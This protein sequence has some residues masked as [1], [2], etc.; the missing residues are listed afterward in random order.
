MPDPF[1][2]AMMHGE[3]PMNK[4]TSSAKKKIEKDRFEVALDNNIESMLDLISF[5]DSPEQSL[6]L[7]PQMRRKK[8]EEELRQSIK[9]SEL[10]NHIDP[11]I[12]I[13]VNEGKQYLESEEYE[14][15]IV[16]FNKASELLSQLDL[17]EP[18]TEEF[19]TILS[20]S[21]ETINSIFKV[22]TAK[23]GEEQYSASLDLFVFLTVLH[24]DNFDYWYR[25]GISA[26][27]CENY[28]LALQAYGNAVSL[29]PEHIGARLFATEC[30]LKLDQHQEAESEYEVAEKISEAIPL[31]DQWREIFEYV[32][33]LIK[34]K[35]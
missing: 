17:S 7:S 31:D 18:I 26:Q 10:N 2:E 34:E 28:T 30:F 11:A 32:G 6:L 25:S 27:L 3:I 35:K 12:K 21:T 16:N 15:M 33:S 1:L 20:I 19:D 23:F 29:N 8:M 5:E 14:E 4:K 13:M 24:F 9:S 22:A